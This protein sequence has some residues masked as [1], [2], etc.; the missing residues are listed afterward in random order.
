VKISALQRH[1]EKREA[2]IATRIDRQLRLKR[3]RLARV[4]LQLEERNPRNLL[5][6]GYAIATDAAGNILKSVAGVNPGDA[7]TVQ[8]R[9]GQLSAEVIGKKD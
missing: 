3:E 9:H 8:L 5:A 1:L 6:R 4:S 7:V 2:E